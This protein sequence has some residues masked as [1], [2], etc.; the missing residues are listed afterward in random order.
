MTD[1]IYYLPNI[2]N[3]P[4]TT[5]Y[6]HSVA[7]GEL[8]D[9][10]ILLTYP[11]SPPSEIQSHYKDIV[12]LQAKNPIRRSAEARH[13]LNQISRRLQNPLYLS[14][15]HYAPVVTG[16][17]SD[18]PW[19]LDVYDD[20]RQYIYQNGK[21][22]IHTV[23]ARLL[24]LAMNRADRAVHTLHPAT[25]KQ[26]TDERR[27]AI[28]GAPVDNITPSFNGGQLRAVYVSSH[29]AGLELVLQAMAISDVSTHLDVYCP[30]SDI[31]TT[32]ATLG[33]ESHVSFHGIRPHQEVISAIVS[34]DI[35]YCMLPDRP[36]WHYS[37]PIRIGE[38]LA[39]GTIPVASQ[40]PGIRALV[41]DAGLLC[42][43]TE[44]GVADALTSLAD[45]D[46]DALEERKRRARR[47]A[48]QIP[49]KREREWFAKQV[50]SSNSTE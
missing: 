21:I 7:I 12:V 4:S 42:S 23:S 18:F 1:V 45:L 15:F 46:P 34:A 3:N 37:F 38:Y 9:S 17:L 43:P 47:R 5:R 39:A 6:N 26:Y 11:D 29:S 44:A 28:N 19:V 20:P 22:N 27:F 40:F 49:W 2:P 24:S 14:T 33:V 41:R 50:L 30:S 48:E 35:G 8:T 10:A 13:H 16:L 31:E 36:D 32:A 25:A